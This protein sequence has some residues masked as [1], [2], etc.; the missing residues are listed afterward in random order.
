MSEYSIGKNSSIEQY[1]CQG[2]NSE[3]ILNDIILKQFKSMDAENRGVGSL[4]PER[5]I[6]EYNETMISKTRQ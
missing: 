6:K 4:C 3:E 2:Q 1:E 5:L